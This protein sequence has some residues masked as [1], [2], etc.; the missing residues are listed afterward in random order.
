M[1]VRG[2]GGGVLVTRCGCGLRPVFFRTGTCVTELQINPPFCLS[3]LCIAP[4]R[5]VEQTLLESTV[6]RWSGSLRSR[7]RARPIPPTEAPRLASD[8]Q[9]AANLLVLLM[10]GTLRE[11]P[12]SWPWKATYYPSP[13][14]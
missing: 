11:E 6:M 3:L 4:A 1:T 2:G 7:S 5:F 12:R 9:V 10:T 14:H 8:G 13:I